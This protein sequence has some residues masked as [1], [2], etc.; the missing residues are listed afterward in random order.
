VCIFHDWAS[1]ID[2]LCVGLPSI[3]GAGSILETA[4]DR[5][6]F[7]DIGH[8]RSA[9]SSKRS[10]DGIPATNRWEVSRLI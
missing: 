5:D 8:R 2:A 7:G 1:K 6:A 10:R 3:R 9:F 4:A